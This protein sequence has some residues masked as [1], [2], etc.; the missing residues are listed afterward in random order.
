MA[1]K[2]VFATAKQR[3]TVIDGYADE[4]IYQMLSGLTLAGFHLEILCSSRSKGRS[5]L[6]AEGKKFKAQHG[7]GRL[8]VR[9]TLDFH[10]RFVVV[11]GCEC[12]HVGASIKDAGSTAFMV[13][14][15]EDSTN[16]SALLQALTTT[17]ANATLVL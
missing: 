13:S 1:L 4:T 9:E 12:V 8:E 17:W 7:L 15:V 6:A 10:D 5:A 3:I 14:A 16:R 11:D 2:K